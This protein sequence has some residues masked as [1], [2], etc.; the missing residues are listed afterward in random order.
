MRG[1]RKRLKPC[2][3]HLYPHFFWMELW[4][5]LIHAAIGR[6]SLTFLG[7]PFFF[8]FFFPQTHFE[9]FHP[10]KS[11]ITVH[12][13]SHPPS[14]RSEAVT[15][16]VH[17][18]SKTLA[19]PS[20]SDLN[21]RLTLHLR[22]KTLASPSISD[23]NLRLTASS[24]NKKPIH[25]PP[26]CRHWSSCTIIL[27]PIHHPPHPFRSWTHLCRSRRSQVSLYSFSLLFDF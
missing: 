27:Y 19:S 5:R 9:P 2:F 24:T 26:H 3:L 10:L 12:L 15:L 11:P 23:L 16:T 20:I 21:L 14:L 1:L 22:S 8:L 17:L 25:Q 7:N 4:P 6:L 18:R 13:L